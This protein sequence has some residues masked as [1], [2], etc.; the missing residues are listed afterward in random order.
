MKQPKPDSPIK[1][2]LDL[3]IP[4]DD[5]LVKVPRDVLDALLLFEVLVDG[6]GVWAVDVGFGGEG[7]GY[8]V[9]YRAELG[10]LGVSPGLLGLHE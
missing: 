4:A 10:D 8:A 3:S 7:K 6:G 9:V 1:V 5:E 2:L